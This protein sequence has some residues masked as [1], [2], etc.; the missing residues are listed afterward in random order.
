LLNQC[1]VI[2][3]SHE[4]LYI[5]G[6]VPYL[7][8][9]E[10]KISNNIFKSIHEEIT[11]DLRSSINEAQKHKELRYT[12]FRSIKMYEDIVRYL[13]VIVVPIQDERND[14][15]LSILFFQSEKPESIRGHIINGNSDDETIQKLTLELDSTKSHL[16]NVIEELETSYEEMQSLNEE[17]Q[18]SNEELQSSNEELETTNE[19]LQSTNE[20]LQTAYSELKVL[21]EDKERRANQLEEL[22]EKLRNQ[23]EDFRKQKEI[24]EGIIDTAPIAI[25]MTDDV[26]NIIFAN[27][28]AE[29]LFG[30]SKKQITSRTFDAQAWQIQDFDGGEI[31]SEK[32]PFSMVKKTYEPVYNVQHAIVTND[33]KLYLNIS[34]APLFDIEGRFYGA[35]FCAVDMTELHALK[36]EVALHKKPDN[37]FD[38]KLLKSLD[39]L[40]QKG[41]IEFFDSKFDF[42]QFAMFD[43]STVLRNKLSDVVLLFKGLSQDCKGCETLHS[44]TKEIDITIAQ[45]SK[46]LDFMLHYYGSSFQ[47]EKSSFINELTHTCKV[48]KYTYEEQGIEVK[49]ELDS[50]NDTHHGA[51]QLKYLFLTLNEYFMYTKQ[52]ISPDEKITLHVKNYKNKDEK[53]IVDF[54]LK[55]VDSLPPLDGTSPSFEAI[56]NRFS[57]FLGFE[58]SINVSKEALCIQMVLT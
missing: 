47:Y 20:E 13:R 6:Q 9:Q 1:V 30:I 29:K 12:P 35:V 58:M 39:E 5:K 48:L 56:K 17:L 34:G 40:K 28:V 15:W 50:S 3:S 31:P 7:R 2:N 54:C 22:S 21:Y 57:Q 43:Y 46:E 44:F 19:E 53:S 33:K 41:Y 36:K 23:T 16:Q 52:K 42:M 18:S 38:T 51:K 24:T 25:T 27:A 11:L 8:H 37:S 14:E 26:G 10:G 55:G 49:L 45:I 32:L 4:I